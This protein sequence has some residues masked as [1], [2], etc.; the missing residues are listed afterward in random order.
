LINDQDF[1]HAANYLKG[2][3]MHLKSARQNQVFAG[4]RVFLE[5]HGTYPPWVY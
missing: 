5:N 3:M 2:L 1:K 4:L